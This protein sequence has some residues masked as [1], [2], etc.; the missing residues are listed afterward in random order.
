MSLS[1]DDINCI[2]LG[3]RPQL[4]Q[5]LAKRVQCP[6]TAADLLQEVYL[7]L[8]H[9]KP[10]PTTEGEVR[11]WLY[12]VASNISV[13]HIRTQQRR[14]ALLEKHYG[15]KSEADEN[16]SPELI[17][18][19]CEE[20]QRIQDLMSDLPPRCMT[21]L[22]MTRIEGQTYAEVATQLG[23]SKSLVEKEVVR[24][25]N[26]LRKALNNEDDET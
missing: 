3:A 19:F 14:S 12:R 15:D 25:L 20:I 26:H 17:A 1:V 21:I 18:L 24:T 6:D 22:R 10:P 9:L 23:I 4:H 11:A 5:F 8:P 16:S 2:Y 13:D 7:R